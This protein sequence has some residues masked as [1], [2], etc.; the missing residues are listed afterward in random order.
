MATHVLPITIHRTKGEPDT[1]ILDEGC[2]QREGNPI[3]VDF[4]CVRCGYCLK[5]DKYAVTC[6]FPGDRRAK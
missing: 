5:I 1:R 6:S 4:R 2:P 3:D